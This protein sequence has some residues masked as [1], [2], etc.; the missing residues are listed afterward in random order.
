MNF[1]FILLIFYSEYMNFKFT[2]Q[3]ENEFLIDFLFIFTNMEPKLDLQAFLNRKNIKQAE[4]AKLIETTPENV[5]RWAKGKGVPS[6]E[7]CFNLLVNGMTQEELFG[8]KSEVPL[9]DMPE[10]EL[11]R[12]IKQVLLKILTR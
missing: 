11:E 4:L 12:K 5:S 6:Y 7:L 3:A 9:S 8:I 2:C 10:D 1:K